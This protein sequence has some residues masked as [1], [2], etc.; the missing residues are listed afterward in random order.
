MDQCCIVL[1]SDTICFRDSVNEGHMCINRSGNYYNKVTI[2]KTTEFKNSVRLFIDYCKNMCFVDKERRIEFSFILFGLF[3]SKLPK[4][5]MF[6]VVFITYCNRTNVNTSLGCQ[7]VT[8]CHRT[9][10]DN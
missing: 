8:R 4:H 1:G 7:R 10:Q 3:V 2:N 6:S 5:C 9:V